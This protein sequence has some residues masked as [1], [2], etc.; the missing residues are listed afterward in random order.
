MK[1]FRKLARW[2]KNKSAKCERCNK[3]VRRPELVVHHI[4]HNR[5]NDNPSN[6]MFMC[7]HCHNSHHHKGKVISKEVRSKMAR[8]GESNGMYN[9]KHSIESIKKMSVSS[10][11]NKGHNI[12]HTEETKKKLSIKAKGRKQRRT[13]CIVCKKELSINQITIH[14]RSKKC[15]K[16]S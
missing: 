9:R 2:L 4:D 8:S 14:Q 5:A 11:G 7:N 15:V 1:N 13:S 3:L 6:F 12:P 10:R 16:D